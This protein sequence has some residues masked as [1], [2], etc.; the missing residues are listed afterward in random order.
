MITGFGRID[1]ISRSGVDVTV[2]LATQHQKVRF[3]QRRYIFYL[4]LCYR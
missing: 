1:A 4:L 2:C 3:T